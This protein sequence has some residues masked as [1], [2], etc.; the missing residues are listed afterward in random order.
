L[1]LRSLLLK[2]WRG[3]R[4]TREGRGREREW[5][6]EGRGREEREGANPQ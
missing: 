2:G 5:K 3:N 6:S 4:G 1:Y